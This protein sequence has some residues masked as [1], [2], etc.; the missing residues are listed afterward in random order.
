MT[1]RWKSTGPRKSTDALYV[2]RI[3]LLQ[4]DP[5][6]YFREY[7]RQKYSSRRKGTDENSLSS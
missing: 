7:P 2:D 6:R 1:S 4:N 5:E 3:R